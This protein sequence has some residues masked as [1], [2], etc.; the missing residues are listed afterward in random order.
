MRRAV[1][2]ATRSLALLAVPAAAQAKTTI[3][4]SGST[5]VAPLATK[6]AKAFLKTKAGKARSSSASSR[7]APTSASRTSHAAA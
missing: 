3:T 5:S 2:T 7:A 6:L 4:V 1:L